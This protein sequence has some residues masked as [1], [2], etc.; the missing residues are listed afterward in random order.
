MF[1]NTKA[2]GGFSVDD[3]AAAK[4]FYADTLGLDVSESNGILT[5]EIAGDRPTIVYP[6]GDHHVP[7]TF[8]ILNFPVDDIEA[9]VA[10]LAA[11]GVQFEHYEG[12]P[13]ET[14]AAGIFRGGGPLIAWFTDP[15]GNVLAVIQT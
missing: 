1:K 14:D 12:T 10:E 15:A 13:T 2:F 9:A 5:L 7:A 3:I 11:R 8:T 6:K 4:Q